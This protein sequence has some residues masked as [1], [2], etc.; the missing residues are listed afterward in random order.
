MTDQDVIVAIVNCVAFAIV[1]IV[2]ASWEKRI[3]PVSDAHETRLTPPPPAFAIW[4]VI[5]SLLVAMCVGQYYDH[6]VVESL[7]GWFLLSCA[8]NIAWLYLY[9]HE[10]LR[11]SALTLFLTTAAIG[12]AYARVQVWST[13]ASATWSRIVASVTFSLYFGWTL[14]AS[15]LNLLQIAP[16][17]IRQNLALTISAYGGSYITVSLLGFALQDP[18]IC[19]PLAW[20]SL[21]RGIVRR[22]AI[23]AVVGSLALLTSVSI[24]IYNG[25]T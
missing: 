7:S 3:K 23:A 4:G 24:A 21:W 12:V 1:L 14:L 8:G 19:L 22:D 2:N 13:I 11:L 10:N 15:L 5:Y 17:K 25:L 16:A 9:T 6:A 20:A 18:C